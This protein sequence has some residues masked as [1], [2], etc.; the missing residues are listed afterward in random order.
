MK[1]WISLGG[2]LHALPA[3]VESCYRAIGALLIT[4]LIR[5]LRVLRSQ[6]ATLNTKRRV[7]DN[8]EQNLRSRWKNRLGLSEEDFDR[9]F[10]DTSITAPMPQT[11]QQVTVNLEFDEDG[12]RY[13]AVGKADRNTNTI[14]VKVAGLDFL[15]ENALTKIHNIDFLMEQVKGTVDHELTHLLQGQY[16]RYAESYPKVSGVDAPEEAEIDALREKLRAVGLRRNQQLEDRVKRREELDY[17]PEQEEP[18]SLAHL[19]KWASKDY[20]LLPSEFDPWII[21]E[22]KM[23]QSFLKY[24]GITNP[25]IKLALRK[26]FLG[27]N[28]PR[29][30]LLHLFNDMIQSW[31]SQ[32][33]C[34][35]EFFYGLKLLKPSMYHLAVKKFEAEYNKDSE[36]KAVEILAP[37]LAQLSLPH[38]L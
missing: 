30:T 28:K 27:V 26:E 6:L 38:L 8:M 29:R 17:E 12:T 37:R 23:F 24:H 21:T 35:S 22:L 20:L 33:H 25:G 7:Y 31:K 4:H 13:L 9:V 14:T 1:I 16:P 18:D 11:N 15:I 36:Q 32:T 34:Q 10:L 2:M 3:D 19:A 5:H